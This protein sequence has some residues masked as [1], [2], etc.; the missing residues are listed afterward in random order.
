[1]TLHEAIQ[2]VLKDNGNE[3][4]TSEIANELNKR[5]LYSKKDGSQITDYQ[6]H[7]RTKNYSQ[8]FTRN[9]SKVGLVK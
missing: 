1:M 7:G 9:G 6:V 8:H 2:I 4:T 5:K 3:M